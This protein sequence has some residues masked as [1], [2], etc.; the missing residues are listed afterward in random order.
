MRKWTDRI[1]KAAVVG[2][3]A[4]FCFQLPLF[5]HQYKLQLLGHVNGLKWQ[6][7]MIDQAA[8]KSGKSLDLYI[9][10]FIDSSDADFSSQGQIMQRTELRLNKLSMALTKLESSSIFTRPFIFLLYLE[11]DIFKS[12]SSAFEPGFVFTIEGVTYAFVGVAFGLLL[13]AALK[14]LFRKGARSLLS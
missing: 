4:F 3:T 5:M 1:L 7:E 6:M 9:K 8:K 12:T 2:L 13:Y 10:K 14:V 11:R